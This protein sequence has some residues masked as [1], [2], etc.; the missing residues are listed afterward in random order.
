MKATI[1]KGIL[2]LTAILLSAG[3]TMNAAA[4][5]RDEA[6]LGDP[7]VPTKTVSFER[8]EL[9]TAE[10]RAE[11]ESRIRRAARLVCGSND[12]REVGTLHAVARNEAC[13]DRAV[14]DAMGQL[15]STR[16][17]SVD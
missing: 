6:V 14:E 9:A 17:A 11:V 4:D 1:N 16:I 5:H 2:P 12:H 3:M 13:F 10:G 7:Q 8:S 15:T